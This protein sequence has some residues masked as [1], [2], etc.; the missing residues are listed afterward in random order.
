NLDYRRELEDHIWRLGLKGRVVFTGF[1]SDVSDLLSDVTVSV[2]PSLSEGLSNAVLE[3][4]A[5]AIPVVATRVGGT[6]EAVEEAVTGLPVPPR[7][8]AALAGAIRRIL[9]DPELAAR[10]G[11]AGRRRVAEHFSLEHM[12]RET[13]RFYSTRLAQTRAERARGFL[14]NPRLVRTGT[15]ASSR[16]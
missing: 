2:L 4:M 1:R 3:S 14:P 16:R 10:L 7:D 15:D 5:S 11:H 8:S 9:E 6:P 12:V 13:E